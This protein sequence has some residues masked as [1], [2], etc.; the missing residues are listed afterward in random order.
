MQIRRANFALGVARRRGRLHVNGIC[1]EA[2]SRRFAE[3]Q[4]VLIHERHQP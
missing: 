1:I 3:Q 4:A 2:T